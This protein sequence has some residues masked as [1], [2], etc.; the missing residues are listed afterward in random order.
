MC[1]GG[2]RLGAWDYFKWDNI[3]PIVKD[4]IIVSAKVVIYGGEEEEHFTFITPEA[5]FHLREWM[6]YRKDTGET[7]TKNSWVMRD[8]W[9]T[10]TSIGRG[11]ITKPKK[12]KSTGIKRL[13]ER[14]LWA[15]GIRKKLEDGKKR[16]EFQADHG[17]RKFFKTHCEIAGMKPI[18]IE[19]LMGHSTGI[20]DSYYRATDNEILSDYLIAVDSLTINEE[21]RLKHKIEELNEKNNVNEYIIASKLME[22]EKEIK[23]LEE[24]S[25]ENEDSLSNLSDQIVQLMTEVKKLKAK[26]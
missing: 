9:D 17:Y 15:Q 10:S 24:K 5:Y 25:K 6:D 7:I 1:S 20:S 2:F 26:S 11:L 23:K 8:L 19:K 4:E 16:H 21:N 13:I 12:L 3:Q 22:K 18:N 14:A